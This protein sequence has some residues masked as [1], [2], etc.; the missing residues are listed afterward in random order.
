MGGRHRWTTRG[1]IRWI[2]PLLAG[3]AFTVVAAALGNPLIPIGTAEVLTAFLLGA[4]MRSAPFRI[5]ILLVIPT[6]TYLLLRSD[7]WASAIRT[8]LLFTLFALFNGL[9]GGGGA[10]WAT[11]M[12]R[13]RRER[14]R[15]R[16]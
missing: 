14:T 5:G 15:H 1:L 4:L 3:I 7:S 9:A 6:A 12:G 13:R 11:E 2:G 16:A 8:A 10:E